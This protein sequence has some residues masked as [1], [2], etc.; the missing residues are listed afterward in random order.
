MRLTL[1]SCEIFHREMCAAVACSTNQ[2]DI[3]FL[4]KGLHDIETEGMRQRLQAAID[5]VDAS[6]YDAVLLGYGLCNNGICG[7]TAPTIP[8]VVPRAHDCLTLFFGSK[9][10]YT[11]YF[12]NHPGV[13]FT[14]TGWIERGNNPGELTK[15]SV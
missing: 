10:R 14:T 11:E 12:T 15:L 9:A 4:V 8:L 6:Q 7:L 1:I 3:E 13:Y 5:R 2:V